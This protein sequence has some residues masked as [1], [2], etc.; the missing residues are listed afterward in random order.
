MGTAGLE[1]GPSGPVEGIAPEDTPP[2]SRVFLQP[3]DVS[4]SPDNTT[5]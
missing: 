1:P 3:S 4:F 2:G 5:C